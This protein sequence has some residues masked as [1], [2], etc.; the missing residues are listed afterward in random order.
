MRVAL[1]VEGT[2]GDVYPM[3]ALAE[4][5]AAAGHHVRVCAP[6]DFRAPVS[7]RGWEFRPVGR[8]VREFLTA[9]AES[10]TRG[11]LALLRATDRYARD[12][13]AAQFAAL[14]AATEGAD[15]ILAAGVQFA[16]RTAAELHGVPFRYV[17][18][19]PV[20]L[21][22]GDYPPLVVP[23]QSLPGW[24]NRALWR[25]MI[26]TW[27]RVLGRQFNRERAA[28]GLAPVADV[29][30]HILSARPVLAADADLA[31]RPLDWTLDVEQVPCLH[32][33]SGPPL[34]PKL[35]SFLNAGAPPI[36]LG[37]GSMTDARPEATTRALLEAVTS[38]GRRA[39]ISRGWAGLGGGALPEGVFA[40]GSVSH[41]RLFPRVAAVV[42]HGGAGTTTTAARAGVPQVV[43][44]HV[45]D[46]FYWARRVSRLG[47]GPPPLPRVRLRAKQLAAV[48][49]AVLD[50][51]VVVERARELG[52]RLRDAHARAPDPARIVELPAG[53]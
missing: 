26:A 11:A 46:Q 12:S 14:P 52:E 44:P 38:L 31:P 6:P 18:Y 22:S 37:F 43:V 21:P 30:R 40:L 17:A 48:L 5:L 23:S 28:L 1:A 33:I 39:L 45:L 50:N 10:M 35:E 8:S 19:C 32:P 9:E 27:N 15:C 53:S 7:E 24:G 49:G 29:H 16:A 20:L 36:Y 3:I 51:D 13:L 34:P 47:L 4:S 2:R 42:H 25:L 41:A